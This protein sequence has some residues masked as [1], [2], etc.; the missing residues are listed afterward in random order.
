MEDVHW[1][2]AVAHAK[3]M[4]KVQI[5]KNVE[6]ASAKDVFLPTMVWTQYE[7]ED[8]RKQSRRKK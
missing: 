8:V 3:D 5:A 4:A 2:L 6:G 1:T 7:P